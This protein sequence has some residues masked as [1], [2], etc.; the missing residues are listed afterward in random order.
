MFY[1]Q[2]VDE[3]KKDV[4]VQALGLDVKGVWLK[5][6]RLSLMLLHF[7]RSTRDSTWSQHDPLVAELYCGKGPA[8]EKDFYLVSAIIN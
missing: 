1:W 5:R 3:S 6:E 2:C 7:F 8:F 4:S